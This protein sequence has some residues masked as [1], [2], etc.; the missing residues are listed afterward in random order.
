MSVQMRL[1]DLGFSYNGTRQIFSDISFE[2][3]SGEIVCL[4]GPNG[5]GKP[6]W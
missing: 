3:N 4:L 6:P 1:E 2:V 5:I